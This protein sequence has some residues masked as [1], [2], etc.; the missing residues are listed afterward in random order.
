MAKATRSELYLRKLNKFLTVEEY[1]D[2]VKSERIRAAF[3]AGASA[4]RS[5]VES[6]KKAKKMKP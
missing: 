2:P 3:W 6:M 4:A 5:L 1:N